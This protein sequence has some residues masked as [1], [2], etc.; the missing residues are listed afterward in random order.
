MKLADKRVVPRVS[1]VIPQRNRWELT[2]ACC[3]SLCRHHAAGEGLE[4]IVVDDG[5]DLAERRK[6][7]RQLRH[8]VKWCEQ[9]Q[10]GVTG[11]WNRGLQESRGEILVLLN[12][13]VV[14]C[15]GWIKHAIEMIEARDCLV[16]AGRRRDLELGRLIAQEKVVSTELLEGWCMVFNRHD[17]ERTGAFDESMKVYWS[18]TDWQWRWLKSRGN[19][20]RL[21][22]LTQGVMRHLGHASTALLQNRSQ[23][24]REDWQRFREKWG[25]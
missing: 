4:I 12:N 10:Q 9:E 7:Y 14:T 24:W 17:Y 3:S 19:R 8:R 1:V 6:G 25:L 22:T 21:R 16:G 18:D 23:V 20:G 15:K 2:V 13:D 5:S 11:A